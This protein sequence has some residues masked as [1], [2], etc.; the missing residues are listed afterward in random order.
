[1]NESPFRRYVP[2]FVS[3]AV[4][5]VVS[6]P[7]VASSQQTSNTGSLL[8]SRP[9]LRLTDS[10]SVEVKPSDSVGRPATRTLPMKHADQTAAQTANKSGIAAF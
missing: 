9:S 5:K 7:L 10:K 8:R 6:V 2:L 4:E 3:V 1:M